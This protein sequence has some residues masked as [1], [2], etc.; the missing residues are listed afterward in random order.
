MKNWIVVYAGLNVVTV[1]AVD[2]LG[3]IYTSG[4]DPCSIIS[5]QAVNTES[6]VTY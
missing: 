3:A 6:P 2:V 4:V 1:T 5:V